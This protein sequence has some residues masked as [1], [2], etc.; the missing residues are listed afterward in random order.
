LIDHI[1]DPL[2]HSSLIVEHWKLNQ[3][4]GWHPFLVVFLS[5]KKIIGFAPLL[6]KSRFGFR[7]V[8]SFDKYTCPE[9][10]YDDYREYCIDQMLTILFRNL[11]CESVDV[12][13]RD[14]SVNQRV[15]EKICRKRKLN[16]AKYPQEGR[17]II[18]ARNSV[19]SFRKS[20]NRK[21]LKEFR[22]IHR[23]LD[24]LGSW[25]I[26]NFD[27][28][29]TSLA[30][31]WE[32]ERH[33]WKAKLMGKKKA[34]KDLGLSA[35]LKGVE[36]NKEGK[37]YFESEVWF[38]ELNNTPIAYVLAMKRKKTEFF[39]KTSFDARFKDAAPG[40][41]L[42]NFLIE[43]VFMNKIAEKID[44]ISNLPFAQ[45]WKPLVVKR[46]NYRILR[47]AG[48]SKARV[49]VFENRIILKASQ[50]LENVKWKKRT[51]SW[52]FPR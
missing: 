9:F 8:C 20:L 24:K 39:A 31:I 14:E 13:F 6:M 29:Q 26:S 34:I 37:S 27:I 48:L 2:L 25:Q 36:R 28:D 16:Y 18:P 46:I 23:K 38:L 41:F 35:I 49:I 22:R 33:S 19:D 3:R 15:L 17:A 51:E 32:I 4:L 44:F 42:M 47:N 40:I 52:P 12:T 45:V 7:Y 30:K 11:N 10:F 21:D 1:D 50:I 43:R 5:E